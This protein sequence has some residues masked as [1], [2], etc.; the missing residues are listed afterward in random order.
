[1][2]SERRAAYALIAP[3]LLII[4]IFVLSPIVQAFVSSLYRDTPFAPRTFIGFDNYRTLVTDDVAL[5]TIEFTLLFVIVS[6]A[7]EI[8]IGL[9]LALVI[10]EHFKGRGLVRAAVL[11]P[12]AIPTVVAGVM[13]KYMLND[14]YGFINLVFYGSNVANY[15]AWLASEW[16]A[17]M[18]IIGADVWKTSSFAALLILA[19][20][21]SIPDD[22]YE[23]ARIDGAGSLK[24]FFRIT[25]P[26]L[27]PAI[28]LALLFRMMDA[29]RVFAL[30]YVMTQGAPGDSTNVLQYYGY[31]KMFPEQ[32]F[33]YGSAISVLVFV[34]IALVA[35]ILIRSVRTRI[36]E[37]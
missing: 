24:R 2:N 18:A 23:A 31:Q 30:V 9:G 36:Y 11:V 28:L 34:M 19:G 26:L 33:G 5:G 6:T 12:W 17:R 37:T 14:Q 21:Q 3:A 13:W 35:I 1:V 25:L 8:L 20:L 16:S 7:L 32:Q 27:R 15:V 29:F 10:N 4:A 22:L